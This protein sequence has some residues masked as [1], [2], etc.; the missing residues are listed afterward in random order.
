MLILLSIAT[1]GIFVLYFVLN[2][3]AP[4]LITAKR[5]KQLEAENKNLHREVALFS[6]QMRHQHVPSPSLNQKVT[7]IQ[8]QTT[9]INKGSSG[10]EEKDSMNTHKIEC[11][12]IHIAMVAAG[13]GA[14]R[15]VVTVLK[16]ILFYRHN[17]IH[18]H[19]IS[20][21][22]GRYILDT[23]FK[24]W[25]LPA[26]DVSFYSTKKA[27]EMVAWIPNSHYSGVY[28]LMKLT[29]PALLSN[30]LQKV[31]VLD[32][33]LMF[34]ADILPLWEHFD[35]IVREGKL[36]GLVENQSDW[37]LG[38]LWEHHEPW[39]A[40]GRGFNTGVILFNLELMRMR[41]WDRLW[42]EVATRTL[43]EY[44]STALADQDI[45]NAI[46]KDNPHL[47]YTLPCFW[48]AQLSEHSLSDYC[49]RN[50]NQFKVV[51][52][53]SPL[54][55]QVTNNHSPYFRNMYKM[56]ENLDGNLFRTGLLSCD[57]PPG[58]AKE[59]TTCTDITDPCVD[60]RREK[61]S[62]YRTHPYFVDYKYQ[63]SSDNDVTLVA[64]LSMD[65]LQMLEPLC[66]H[67]SGPLSITLYASD[68]EVQQ[69]IEFYSSSSLKD[70]KRLGLH[71]VYKSSTNF[72]PINYLRNVALNNVNTPY[73]FLSDIDFIPMEGAYDYLL[74]A[75][76]VLGTNLR[77]LI[78]PAFETLFYKFT[79][80]TNK[81]ELLEMLQDGRVSTFRSQVW[82]QGHAPT[83]FNHWMKATVPYKVKWAPNFEPYVV[84]RSNVSRY[85][86]RFAG[87]GW[88]KVSHIM[89]L[90]AQEYKFV[91]LPSVFMIH[92]PHSPSL[93]I[94]HFRRSKIYRDC[95]Q[96]LK[97]EFQRELERTYGVR[98]NSPDS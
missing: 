79:H 80:P 38:Q 78:V 34:A 7:K 42:D 24:T 96:V 66:E 62:V 94:A 76:K 10:T 97:K 88:N 82:T 77:A 68:S 1:V 69:F 85:D 6:E 50:A 25:R 28:G 67:W 98:Q 54:K 86:Q 47:H 31:I 26:V 41:T 57:T 44:E 70:Y 89:E 74:E 45:I 58:E 17:P 18:L 61:D 83:N 16:S 30:S 3:S 92:M 52:W 20:D 63:S 4:R 23:V 51:H 9:H 53:N 39:P 75:V 93:D 15:S 59:S 37:Y 73:V 11:E 49:F 81:E 5:V 19:F 43:L 46:I 65:R 12:T 32:T 84:V 95:V 40:L 22:A 27:R 90:E 55:L 48:N 71:V 91:V 35:M 2:S 8:I 72:Y 36:L 33:D 64:Q 13:Y 56:F 14:A 21:D 87:F 29:V 60:F